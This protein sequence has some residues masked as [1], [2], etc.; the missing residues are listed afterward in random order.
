M[1]GLRVGYRVTDDAGE[2]RATPL[3]RLSRRGGRVTTG[4]RAGAPRDGMSATRSGRRESALPGVRRADSR[5]NARTAVI[6]RGDAPKY[7]D[8]SPVPT[9]V[10]PPSP[11]WQETTPHV[12]QREV[13]KFI[14]SKYHQIYPN[15]SQNILSVDG[16]QI[17]DRPHV[18]ENHHEKMSFFCHL[19]ILIR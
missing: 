5:C 18:L 8:R 13:A 12:V 7:R 10:E 6:V 17:G 19:V 2:N 11:R 9:D 4:T 16:S 3:R 15:N 1:A 14:V